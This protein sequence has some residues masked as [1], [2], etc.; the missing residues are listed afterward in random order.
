MK[1]NLPFPKAA[2]VPV[3]FLLS[4]S[5]YSASKVVI[6]RTGRRYADSGAKSLYAK[7]Y[8][9][10]I[11]QLRTAIRL[12]PDYWPPQ[13]D[14]GVALY[15]VGS[16]QEA[17]DELRKA[18]RMNSYDVPSHFYLG[19]ALAKQHKTEEARNEFNIAISHDNDSE[20]THNARKEIEKFKW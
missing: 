20:W 12:K 15:N 11:T 19:K 8:Q 13:Y 6:S 14:L 5:A 18:L 3:L 7:D 9:T 10:A 16:T 17:I 4:I 2:I 1:F